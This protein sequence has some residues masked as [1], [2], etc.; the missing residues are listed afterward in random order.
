VACLFLSASTDCCWGRACQGVQAASHAAAGKPLEVFLDSLRKA[1]DCDAS[2]AS[3][4][5]AS[6]S[7]PGHSS[8]AGCDRDSMMDDGDDDDEELEEEEL[9]DDFGEES[10]DMG[11]FEEWLA[12]RPPLF[13]FEGK[14][15]GL[16]WE[17]P[18]SRIEKKELLLLQLLA[19]EAERKAQIA[20]LQAA[21]QASPKARGARLSYASTTC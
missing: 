13:R 15:G 16:A 7:L 6:S 5:G 17:F 1:W 19:E 12:D 10:E 14:A 20:E 4:A 11:S 9:E 21:L 2:P 8:A 18:L 3:I